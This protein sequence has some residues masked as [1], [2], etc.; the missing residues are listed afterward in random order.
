M[1]IEKKDYIEEIPKTVDVIAEEWDISSNPEKANETQEVTTE[2]SE[3][4]SEL[5]NDIVSGDIKWL[6]D[7]LTKIDEMPDVPVEATKTIKDYLAE[8]NVMWAIT[9]ALD[10]I[11]DMFWAFLNTKTWWTFIEEYDDILNNLESINFDAMAK[12]GI[13]KHIKK[14][15][16]KRDNKTDINKKLSI[17]YIISIFKEQLLKKEKPNIKKIW[18]LENNI[19]K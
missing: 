7:A 18:L 11:G 5:M 4:G 17:T 8:W 3:S 9:E 19:T 1:S 14:L 6:N 15:E 16:I 13:E 12:S 2:I 10:F